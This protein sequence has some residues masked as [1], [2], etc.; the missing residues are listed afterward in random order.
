MEPKLNDVAG[1]KATAPSESKPEAQ[2]NAA[3]KVKPSYS[4]W[5]P[6]KH[7]LKWTRGERKNTCIF[8]SKSGAG[9]RPRKCVSSSILPEHTWPSSDH[10]NQNKLTMKKQSR[11]LIIQQVCLF[12][13]VFNGQRW[14]LF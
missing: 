10:L 11:I 2:E 13:Q 6:G 1:P 4:F 12:W 3:E 14:K 5:L 8:T 9:A 7:P